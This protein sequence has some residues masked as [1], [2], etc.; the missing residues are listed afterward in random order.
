MSEKATSVWEKTAL[1]TRQMTDQATMLKTRDMHI[2]ED[3]AEDVA[4]DD[5]VESQL[6]EIDGIDL[7]IKVKSNFPIQIQRNQDGNWDDVQQI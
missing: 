5:V 4:P 2:V 1:W 6:Y 7:P 3:L